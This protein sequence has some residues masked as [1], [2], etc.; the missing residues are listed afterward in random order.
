MTRRQGLTGYGPCAPS[1]QSASR[2]ACPVRQLCHGKDERK[3]GGGSAGRLGRL[4]GGKARARKLTATQR[5][6]SARKTLV[7]LCRSSARTIK[8]MSTALVCAGLNCC[9]THRPAYSIPGRG[10]AAIAGAVLGESIRYVVGW[11]E[12]C[13]NRGGEFYSHG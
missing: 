6:A 13:D 7:R 9:S 2:A 11:G 1:V 3:C 12:P 10:N 5:Q 4:K 8:L